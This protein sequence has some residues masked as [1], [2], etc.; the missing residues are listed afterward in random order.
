[1]MSLIAP[2]CPLLSSF[3]PECPLF[4]DKERSINKS[5][6]QCH[7]ASVICFLNEVYQKNQAK[8]RIQDER[9]D[10]SDGSR[11]LDWMRPLA[12]ARSRSQHLAT[13]I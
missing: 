6:L 7:V 10:A 13:G 12:I 1:M 2:Y 9:W 8:V 4:R 11:D 3:V 5:E